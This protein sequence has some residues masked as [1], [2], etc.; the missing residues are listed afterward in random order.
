MLRILKK[1]VKIMLIIMLL[2]CVTVISVPFLFKD[3]IKT[4]LLVEIDNNIN[5]KVNF[6]ELGFSSFKKFPHFTIT[7]HDATV[8]G[9]DDFA[10]DTLVA[11]KELSVSL[12][13]YKMIKGQDIEINGIQLE[14][15]LIYARILAN[16]KANY[17][18][19]KPDTV[20]K[21]KT[22]GSKFE[23]NIDKWS[24]NNGRIVYD[25]KL[26][27]TYIEVGGL[28]HMGSGDFKQEIS[29]LDITTK[30]SDLTIQYNGIRYFT[31]KLFAADLQME[32]NLKEKKFTF[33]DH[34]FQLGNFK[35]GFEGY[36]KLLTQ[37]YET[38]LKFVVKETS[39]KNLLSLLPGIYQKDIEEIDAKGE[40]SCNGFVKGIYDVKDNKIPAFHID[41]KVDEAIFKYNRLPKAVEKINFD[42]V[43]DNPDGNPEHSSYNLKA[44]DF[45]INKKPVHGSLY[46]KG[47]KNFTINADIKLLADLAEVEQIYPLKD[48]TL[49]GMVNSE[50]KINGKYNDS[51]KILP[52]FHVD[53]QV[54]NALFKYKKLPKSIDNIN[55]HLVADNLDGIT[56][57]TNCNVSI[58]HFEID[59]NP[60]HGSASVKG[61]KDMQVSA[62]IKLT[63]DLA[64]LEKIYPID[65]VIVK[66]IIN[67]EIKID[68]RYNDSLKLFPK[69][70]VFLTV[71]KGYIKYKNAPIEMD[72]IHI[73]AEVTNTTG[74]IADTR[75]SLNNL[76]FLLDNEPFVMNGT[77]SDLKDYNYKVKI[78]GLLDLAKLTQIYPIVNT[79]LKGTLDFDIST[80]GNLTKIE[81][82]QYTQL[83]TNGTL[84]VKN[85]SYKNTDIAF[86]VHIDDALFTFTSHKIVLTRFQ[87]EFGK[88]NVSLS[89]H[90]YNYIPYILKNDAPIKGDLTL[91]CDTLDLNQW[92]PASI[93]TGT[94]QA[95]K[96]STDSG[97]VKPTANS[98]PPEV[99]IIPTNVG[100]VI[101]SDIKLVKFGTM[102]IANL[103][104]AIRIQD[105]VLTMNETGFNTLDSKMNVSG[106]YSTKNV[107]HPM[108]DLDVS[109]DKLDFNKAYKTFVD[110]KGTCPASG[111]FSTKYGIR[112]EL[113]PGFSPIYST[114]NGSGKIIIDS[115]SVKGMKLMNHLKRITKK[116]EFK[117][118][119]L[120]DVKIDTEIKNGRFLIYPFTFQVSKFLTEVE[121]SQGLVD[122][123]IDYSVKL[124]VPPFNKLRIPVS[125]TGTADKPII[126]MGKGFDNSDFDKL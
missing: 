34:N 93:S 59:K 40:F 26:Q 21:S 14:E 42:F 78:D 5:A 115:V 25:D 103:D 44:F 12:N 80:A 47:K 58:F 53:M 39:F 8:I 4:K 64:H 73:N 100:F 30:V 15:P 7:L 37:G 114:L 55:F 38:D 107:K 117:D 63:V 23:I 36:F 71:E 81:A 43:A 22:T 17:D 66:G 74:K 24:I 33:K 96:T 87:A 104:G 106:D 31:K 10:G 99:L 118:P 76:T 77:V 41:L 65:G 105:G 56:E 112:G 90:L 92:F 32:M 51:L 20:T 29:D 86:P 84:E 49:K 48:I 2:L 119:K 54:E 16:G 18:I 97:A 121:G 126:K 28:F 9:I 88:S 79:T 82:K 123:T 94:T 91:Y 124:S 61:L 102:D 75:I 70:D 46:V 52:A 72:S 98:K 110:P 120:A 95:V 69:A 62:D 1:T 111:N 19:T 116:E 83:K 125:I 60:V 68:G 50:V 108:F 109:I 85:V 27:K 35:F 67:S 3:K 113:T 45:E 57:H 89:G 11:A 122:E 6:S 13:L 101:D